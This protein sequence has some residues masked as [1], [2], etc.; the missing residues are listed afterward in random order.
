MPQVK[1]Q[2]V[3]HNPFDPLRDGAKP[4]LFETDPESEIYG[5]AG[6]AIGAYAKH[7][8][9]GMYDTVRNAV[10]ASVDSA[11]H[12]YGA[13]DTSD[14]YV[15]P[16]TGA[17]LDAALMVTGKA[18]AVPAEAN[19][20]RTGVGLRAKGDWFKKLPQFERLEKKGATPDI[21]YELTG[22]YRGGDDK[23]RAWVPDTDSGLRPYAAEML[24]KAPEGASAPMH[25][26]WD[27]PQLFEA[28]PW[29]KEAKVS[30]LDNGGRGGG[31]YDPANGTIN[32]YKGPTDRMETTLHHEAVHMIQH[33]EE[34]ANGGSKQQFYP[35]DFY[36][37]RDKLKQFQE[38]VENKSLRKEEVERF[39][40]LAREVHVMEDEAFQKYLQLHGE[41]EARDAPYMKANPGQVPKY[42]VPQHVN[43]DLAPG[44]DVL[45]TRPFP[46][47]KRG[48]VGFVEVEHDPWAGVGVNSEIKPQAASKNSWETEGLTPAQAALIKGAAQMRGG[49][50]VEAER[51]WQDSKG[52]LT[53]ALKDLERQRM[54]AGRAPDPEKQL[55]DIAEMEKLIREKSTK[56]FVSQAKLDKIAET[57]Q[58]ILDDRGSI[59]IADLV[60]K[61][62]KYDTSLL[63]TAIDDLLRRKR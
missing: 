36:V 55:A 38:A 11:A 31:F 58:D 62:P 44:Q 6:P 19:T 50:D 1:L 43:P 40:Q 26:I 29:L 48:P 4:S 51:V 45:V 59:A 47:P 49:L 3:D 8:G 7:V 39:R 16:S 2:P 52:S 13:V 15:D 33:F 46:R 5:M 30:I 57:A 18:G 28:Y 63:Q 25:L 42:R 14:S 23:L 60:A 53:K 34:F 20:L 37:K 21:S 27:H 35:P 41:S 24:K 17:A 22:I 54:F 12:R 61:F 32:V 10:D 9:E 56:P